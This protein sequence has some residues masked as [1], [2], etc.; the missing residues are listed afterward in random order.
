MS[1]SRQ[2]FAHAL[3][4]L[5]QRPPQFTPE[6][7]KERFQEMAD[8]YAGAELDGAPPM[9]DDI[10]CA[11]QLLAAGKINQDEYVTLCQNAHYS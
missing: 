5:S 6:Q 11:L 10:R 2:Q 1:V 3:F 8:A 7:T 9:P 4:V